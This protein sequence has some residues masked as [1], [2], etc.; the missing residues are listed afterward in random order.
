MDFT[1]LSPI[2]A[3]AGLMVLSSGS[4]AAKLLAQEADTVPDFT[5]VW[6]RDDTQSEDPLEIVSEEVTYG[7][8]GSFSGVTFGR[9]GR[10]GG[11]RGPGRGGDTARD[12]LQDAR[13]RL[14]H[15]V[16]GL[17]ALSIRHRDPEIELR[18]TNR[19][20][21]VV[22]TDGRALGD[23][24]G[25]QTVSVIENGILVIE[26]R[27]AGAQL[28]QSMEL[29]PDGQRLYVLTDIQG[30]GTEAVRFRTVYDRVGDPPAGEPRAATAG[31][32]APPP[33]RRSPST[34]RSSTGPSRSALV[35]PGSAPELDAAHGGSI[36][37]FL[38]LRG[39]AGVATSGK[40]EFQTLTIE[41]SV[42][43]VEFFLD[44]ER[45]ARKT[46]PPFDAK[47]DIPHPPREQVVR[48]EAFGG[49]GRPLGHDEMV[50]NRFD[51]PFRVRVA[52]IGRAAGQLT[53]QA[54][55]SVPRKAE[56]EKVGFFLGETRLEEATQ[57]PFVVTIAAADVGPTD[58][59]RVTARL[60]DGREIEDVELLQE[61]VFS[62]EVD[63]HLL[64][65]QVLVTDKSGAPV[66]GL[67]VED[68]EIVDGGGKRQIERLYTSQNVALVL[69]L[70][71]DSSYSM[72]LLWPQTRAAT[73]SFLDT[74]LGARDRAFLV[75]FDSRVRLLQP[76]TGD[77]RALA[78]AMGRLEPEGGTALYDSILYSL[79][80]YDGEPGRRALIVITDGV[81]WGSR[82][83]PKRTIEL[84]ERLGVP[85]YIIA[86]SARGGRGGAPG[87]AN[88]DALARNQL[89]LITKPTGGRMFHV[90]SNEQIL[91][92][93]QRI[94]DELSRQYVI[95]YYTEAAPD[96][97]SRP[98]VKILRKGLRV[99]AAI[100]LDLAD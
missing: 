59:V 19:E 40:V 56:L 22:Y 23:G 55:V 28:M 4:G 87:A 44:G 17:D 51:P 8:G 92:A 12:E 64:Q 33:L 27:N 24:F 36:I 18:D 95:T 66:S 41:P 91:A 43:S 21:R 65:L 11:G 73:L 75:D 85:V 26:T 50:I 57:G 20:T 97:G 80:Q 45:V 5:G 39:P 37:R 30:R 31:D 9:R 88:V 61:G 72:E 71:V 6:V 76:L 70:A 46:V 86:M 14:R 67:V 60:A 47:I 99:R 25:S 98:Q 78:W 82:A 3:V 94:R 52:S 90:V 53:V 16:Q 38:P 96:L 69:G 81:D 34:S 74:T 13:E 89:S 62:E 93:F 49:A 48:A 63:V 54:E 79:L 10:G 15:L 58:Y 77:K 68:F 32:D 42:T 100:P 1:K 29:D 35:S 7:P 83:D 2:L 84:G